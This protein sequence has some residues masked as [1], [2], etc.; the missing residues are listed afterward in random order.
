MA[1]KWYLMVGGWW[2]P[3]LPISNT[4]RY[5]H[6]NITIC[7]WTKI[8]FFF[9]VANIL[10]YMYVNSTLQYPSI[11]QN[12]NLYIN[13]YTLQYHLSIYINPKKNQG[14][15]TINQ[16]NPIWS[17]IHWSISGW[18]LVIFPCLGWRNLPWTAGGGRGPIVEAVD[19]DQI[20]PCQSSTKS[21]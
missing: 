18:S 10:Q 13:Q 3:F 7:I 16:D 1:K 2:I 6:L 5:Q 12:I 14:N 17:N 19:P 11:L 4:F 15:I 20:T 21:M 8:M 9:M